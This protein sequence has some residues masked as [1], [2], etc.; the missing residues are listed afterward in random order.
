L[1]FSPIGDRVLDLIRAHFYIPIMPKTEF[2]VKKRKSEEKPQ[3]MVVPS[4]SVRAPAGSIWFDEN[5]LSV[6]IGKRFLEGS[7]E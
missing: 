2:D 4:L 7:F 3:D 1:S 5:L 6:Q